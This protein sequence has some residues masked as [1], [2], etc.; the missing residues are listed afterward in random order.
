MPYVATMVIDPSR[1]Q[2]VRGTAQVMRGIG[3]KT[4]TARTGGLRRS[5]WSRVKPD[6]SIAILCGAQ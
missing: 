5:C 2:P 1:V 4:K 6:G 3:T